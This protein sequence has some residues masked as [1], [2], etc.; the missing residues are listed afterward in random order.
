[1]NIVHECAGVIH[2]DLKPENMLIDDNDRIKI[3]DF[4][5]SFLI[6]NGSDE[7]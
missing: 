4:G 7:L 5:V 3:G 2:R 6:E 1:L